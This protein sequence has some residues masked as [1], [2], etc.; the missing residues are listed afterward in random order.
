MPKIPLYGD[1]AGTTIQPKISSLG[2]RAGAV[3]ESSGQAL[4]RAGADVSRA[5]Q[6]YAA[7]QQQFESAKAKLEFDFA[8]A[9]KKQQ[10]DSLVND[11]TSRAYQMA[12]DF[13]M[14]DTETSTTKSAQGLVDNVKAPL[15]SEIEGLDITNNQ[16]QALLSSLDR[17]LLPKLGQAKQQAF[18]RN[19]VD[20]SAKTNARLETYI[21]ELAEESD[22]ESR[23]MKMA[24]GIELITKA[25]LAGQSLSYNVR[26]FQAETMKRTFNN[27]IAAAETFDDLGA[28]EDEL[29]QSGSGINTF[30]S[31]A[32]IA[33]IRAS[34]AKRKNELTAEVHDT[35]LEVFLTA[36][37][38]E[39][40][41]ASALS[42]MRAGQ[43]TIIIPREDG[44]VAV[45]LR[46]ASGRFKTTLA[47]Q[48]EAEANAVKSAGNY[49]LLERLSTEA[50][51]MTREELNSLIADAERLDGKA[52]G[53][54]LSNS[55]TLINVAKRHL[56][57]Y[58]VA[59]SSQIKV[60]TD[61]LKVIIEANDGILNDESSSLRDEII[62]NRI[63]LEPGDTA[64]IDRLNNEI[65]AI[66]DAG[67]IFAGVK[68]S[69][70][71]A[72]NE[73]QQQLADNL[74]ASDGENALYNKQALSSFNA[75]IENRKSRLEKDPVDFL[76]SDA[77]KRGIPELT[78]R[79]LVKAQK[80]M[81][82]AD[83]DIRVASDAE[84]LSF[85]K[86]YSDPSL[87]YAEKSQIGN[88]F[89]TRFGRDNEGRIL[90]N[91]TSQ[92]VLTLTD[93]L[94]I[95]NPQ[96]ARM[97]PVMQANEPDSVSLAKESLGTARMREIS[98]AVRL[99]NT[100]YSQSII[101]GSPG[102]I[103]GA[104]ATA[105]RMSHVGAMNEVIKNT[106]AYFML[107]GESDVQSAV[108]KAIDNVVNSQFSFAEKGLNKPLRLPK[109][110]ENDARDIGE[111]LGF[112]LKNPVNQ[113]YLLRII[114]PPIAAGLSVEDSK[115]QLRKKLPDAYWV[116]TTDNKGA[117][118]VYDTGDMVRRKEAPGPAGRG[119]V[120]PFITI[121]FS[122][123][124][125]QIRD[126]NT[127]GNTYKRAQVKQREIF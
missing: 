100:Q 79:Q 117:Y 82:I 91:L 57:D 85:Q 92:G 56:N 115:N 62:A 3:F 46:G 35:A 7:N 87:T 124:A 61:S 15:A 64:G 81:G 51:D 49:A 58:D 4:A 71:L 107:S 42:Q 108:E 40:E 33:G 45:E 111:I 8:M 21:S 14:A 16:K 59:L 116:T 65:Q 86:Q 95:A 29:S 113:D 32:T 63:K 101:G 36:N 80:K 27:S 5:A 55:L 24:E 34:A 90:R 121:K 1:T 109:A 22:S 102:N 10:T 103:L 17:Q 94:N 77:R 69:D 54:S 72:I 122:D 41:Q 48:F 73:A 99:T 23:A 28:I 20:A 6:E 30:L 110:L 106:A 39:E 31:A 104:G 53:L 112:Y 9:E 118:L 68:L 70:P 120:N 2:P 18:N 89:I 44:D 74:M 13:I 98:E 96:N 114:D 19:L 125:P 50:A 47:N 75:M 105:A 67:T 97:F 38:S 83:I 37:L 78:P 25:N 26:S 12:D 123:L 119:E 66:S 76:Q 11:Y 126:L 88:E 60:D 52:N 84:I 127:A 93:Q 43:D